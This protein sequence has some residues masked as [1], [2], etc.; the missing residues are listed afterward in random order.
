VRRRYRWDPQTKEM[1]EIPPDS[2]DESIAP[3]VWN[4]LPAYES[5]IDGRPVDGR[6]QRRNDLART[7]CRP[8]E[9]FAQ[10]SKEAAK[11]RT[12]HERKLDQRVEESVHRTWHEMPEHV[13]RTL[14]NRSG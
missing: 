2:R 4:D 7:G 10:E 12:E 14:R 9:G 8:Y 3:A 13:R 1:V 6:R 5:P 11:V